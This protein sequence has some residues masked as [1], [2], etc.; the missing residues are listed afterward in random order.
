VTQ[1]RRLSRAAVARDPS[2]E[3]RPGVSAATWWGDDYR[4]IDDPLP[5]RPPAQ[6]GA[7]FR[8]EDIDAARACGEVMSLETLDKLVRLLK[9][10]PQPSVV[11]STPWRPDAGPAWR[12]DQ[13]RLWRR[14][15]ETQREE[16]ERR[17][18]ERTGRILVAWLIGRWRR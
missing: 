2:R 12:E 3:V 1:R 11:I 6:A 9:D 7:L 16:R 8:R 13:S 4:I 14:V 15:A 10:A 17:A 18:V 5:K